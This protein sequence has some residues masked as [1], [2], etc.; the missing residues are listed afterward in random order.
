MN[1]PVTAAREAVQ[2]LREAVAGMRADWERM[3]FF[4]R[5]MARAGFARRTGHDADGWDRL[6]GDLAR[7]LGGED[8][9]A[10]AAR[11]AL[12]ARR[13][14]PAALERLAEHYRGAPER[15]GKLMGGERLEAV[16]RAAATREQA[17]RELIAALRALG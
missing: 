7:A 14:L 10:E 16:R 12:A 5:P 15:A 9:D 11:R 4:V 3:P 6:L 17:A 13:E 2:R 1:E 8:G